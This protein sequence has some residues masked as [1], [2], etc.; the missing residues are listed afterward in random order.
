MSQANALSDQEI[1]TRIGD[2]DRAAFSE[3]YRRYWQ[4]LYQIAWNVLRDQES[5]ME[6]IQDVFV[7][8]WD[9]RSSLQ[10]NSVPSYLRAAVK[11]K[12]T[13]ILRSNKVREGCFVDL[14]ELD[15]IQ[16]SIDDDPLELKELKLVIIQMSKKLPE[17]ARLIFELSRNEQLSNREIA[18]KLGIS[19][20]TVENQITIALKKLRISM[21]QHSLWLFFL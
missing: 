16:L 6:V 11:Y 12:V 4:S 20:K 19:E 2:N 8:L 5:C 13:D 21:D 15:K 14:N 7:W 3:L 1:L 18:D 17:R 10:I 9:H